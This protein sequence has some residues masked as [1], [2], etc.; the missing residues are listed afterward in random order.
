MLG[1]WS[2][3]DTLQLGH[4]GNQLSGMVGG[5]EKQRARAKHVKQVKL[6]LTPF[7]IVQPNAVAAARMLSV[8]AVS[9]AGDS[10]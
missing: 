6:A 8:P 4:R 7:L 5:T 10:A 3:V 1:M 2:L 9:R